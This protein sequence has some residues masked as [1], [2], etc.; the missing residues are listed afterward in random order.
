MREASLQEVVFG[1]ERYSQAMSGKRESSGK[2]GSG[3][4]SPL[5]NKV[6]I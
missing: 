6:E 1:G 5:E 2:K 3:N 4:V